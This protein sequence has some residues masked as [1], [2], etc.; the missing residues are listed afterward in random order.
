MVFAALDRL[1][2]VVLNKEAEGLV[3]P[4]AWRKQLALQLRICSF[5]IRHE[6]VYWPLLFGATSKESDSPKG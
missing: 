3:R 2:C 6:E 4:I 5:R 1:E